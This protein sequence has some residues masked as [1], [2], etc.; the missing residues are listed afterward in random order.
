MTTDDNKPK[1]AP[2]S[3]PGRRMAKP[4]AK[5]KPVVMP[6]QPEAKPAEESEAK[7]KPKLTAKPKLTGAYKALCCLKYAS[8]VNGETVEA[9]PGDIVI[10]LGA[11][12]IL[13]MRK[14]ESIEPHIEG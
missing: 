5:P 6:K 1:P 12:D 7:P 8:A 3:N 9:R 13:R 10:N 2:A 4:A 14:S 11:D